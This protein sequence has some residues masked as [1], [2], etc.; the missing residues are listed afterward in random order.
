MTMM[1]NNVKLKPHQV[2]ALNNLKPGSI[3]CGGTGSGKSLVSLKYFLLKQYE[4]ICGDLYIIT[5]ARKRDELEWEEE[6]LKVGGCFKEDSKIYLND[7]KVIVDSWNNLHKY[8]NVTKSFF[9]FDEQRVVGS[10]EWSKNF[11]KISRNNKWILLSATPGDTWMDYIP[12]FVA[13]GFYKNR[14][15]F[16][17]R[18]VVYDRYIKYKPKAFLNES[19]L[20]RLRDSILVQMPFEKHTVRHKEYIY[21]EYDKKDFNKILKDRWDPFEE[22]P[23]ANSAELCRLLRRVVNNKNKINIVLDLLEKHKCL[24]VFYNFNYELEML[25]EIKEIKNIQIAEWNGKKHEEIP[26][27]KEWLYLVQYSSGAE[28]WNCIKTN[29]IFF[30]SLNY[31]YKIMEQAAGRI[32]RL[33]TPFKDL[34][35]YYGVTDSL[36]DKSILKAIK[37]KKKFNETAFSKENSNS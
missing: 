33:T 29:V 17:R 4:N 22:K 36:I 24:I 35:Y 6:C 31:S 13:N 11:I 9:I 18:H 12:V 34:Y 15:Q 26:A 25:R 14:T 32:D 37:N 23:I 8:L 7:K 21:N 30:F 27:S 1:K 28:G 2:K 3:L 10:G 16:I 20:K 19:Y 5:T